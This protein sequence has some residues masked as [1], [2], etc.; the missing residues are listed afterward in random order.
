MKGPAGWFTGDAW[1]DMIPM[2]DSPHARGA[3]VHFAPGARTGWHAHGVGQMV[4]VTYGRGRIQARGE[5]IITLNAGDIV[6]AP[7]NEWHWHGAAP[8]HFMTHLS[9]AE[10]P[11]SP[12][13]PAALF[14]DLVTDEEYLG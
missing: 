13:E 3:Y 12:D 4:Q 11:H 5:K 10:V 8:D 1:I 2:G 14:G 7:S 9:I 6:Y